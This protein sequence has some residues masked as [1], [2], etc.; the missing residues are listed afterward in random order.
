MQRHDVNDT[1][2]FGA[3]LPKAVGAMILLH[4]RGSSAADIAS[5]GETLK[6]GSLALLAPNAVDGTWYPQRF[7]VPLVRNEPWLSSAI[8][9]IDQL[10]REIR[11][12]GISFE[13]IGL[14]GFS[15]GACLAL[16]YVAR[17][18]RRYGFVAV[19]ADGSRVYGKANSEANGETKFKVP[20]NTKFL[21]LVVSGAPTEHWTHEI[22]GK[23][24]NDEQW[25]YQIQLSG[26]SFDDSV[27]K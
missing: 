22:D 4:G 9:V 20:Q 24:E 12:A 16:E 21:W 6:N 5:L 27:L 3:P 10:M 25:P 23:D 13:R 15:Q 26:T 8:G 1:L 7:F 18:P 14:I 2:R 11:A 17:Y 19:K